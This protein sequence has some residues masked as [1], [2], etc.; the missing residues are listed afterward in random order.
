MKV[1]ICITTYNRS[2]FILDSINNVLTQSYRNIELIIIDDCSKDEHRSRLL[3]I[4]KKINDERICFIFNK[5]NMGLAYNRNLAIKKSNGQFFTFK[6]DDDGWDRNHIQ[7][8]IEVYLV[9]KTDVI[10]FGYKNTKGH[11][12]SYRPNKTTLKAALLAGHTPP[13]S[14]QFYKISS[15]RELPYQYNTKIT[16]GV[17]HDLWI[18]IASFYGEA[19]IY[20]S[21]LATVTPNEFTDNSERMTTNFTKRYEG[22]LASL[23]IWSN[24]L[25]MIGGT[26]FR[27]HFHTEYHKYLC[28]RFL[29]ISLS[30]GDL[31]L[32]LILIKDTKTIRYFLSI[33]IF[34]TRNRFAQLFGS[35]FFI[36]PLFKEF[37]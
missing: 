32:L 25:E 3:S 18:N 1:S 23:E 15:L 35:K 26:H 37:K 13:V 29:Q 27:K 5:K 34:F 4:S 14:G 6:D 28:K 33:M 24:Q 9:N 31:K 17:D 8:C 11:T 10:C 36:C 2:G 22:I 16:S 30:N 20:F 12:Y 19:T 21:E 7:N